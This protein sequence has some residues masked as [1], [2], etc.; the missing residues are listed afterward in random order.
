MGSDEVGLE[1]PIQLV[2]KFFFFPHFSTHKDR[3][4][5]GFCFL[6]PEF[7]EEKEE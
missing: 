7:N 4:A 2:G 6:K 1:G 3:V 5:W